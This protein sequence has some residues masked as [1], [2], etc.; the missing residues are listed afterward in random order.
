MSFLHDS[1][2]RASTKTS[3]RNR[4]AHPLRASGI[5]NHPRSLRPWYAAGMAG[6]V[7]W[8]E[9]LVVALPIAVATSLVIAVMVRT[10]DHSAILKRSQLL[11]VGMTQAE[12]DA[13]MRAECG[14]SFHSK[15]GTHGLLYRSETIRHYVEGFD[16][17]D[18]PVRV[19]LDDTGRVDLIERG[20]H[21]SQLDDSPLEAVNRTDY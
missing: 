13:V 1:S 21:S 10:P 17:V 7:K 12:V 4:D 5:I 11:K 9:A 14:A 19:R 18:W 15:H 6:S 8:R 16:P 20:G 3:T 2:S